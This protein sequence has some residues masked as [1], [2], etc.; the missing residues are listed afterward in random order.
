MR[1]PPLQEPRRIDLNA[2]LGEGV[3]DD[4]A[5]LQVVTSANV[6]CGFHAGDAAVMR[7]VC[8]GAAEL[9]VV[10][11]AQV[12]YADRE[13]FGRRRMDVAADVLTDWVAEQ[14]AALDEI[15]A[16]AGTRVRYVK[17]HGA[18]YN[19]I[20][21]DAEQAAAVLR[22]S[23]DLPVLGLPG[24]VVL[25]LAS[26]QGREVVAEGFP[27][28]GY[29]A[30]GRLIPRDRP[31]ALVEG[32]DRVAAHAVALAGSGRLR[33]VCVHGDSPGAVATAEAVRAALLADGY[34]VRAW[35]S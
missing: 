5:L 2:D 30:E 9:G 4:P 18:L 17:A 12:S 19:R 7:A 29:T 11:G 15:A 6:A 8:A 34:D 3:T 14:V 24:S 1:P 31:G 10:V 28:R 20:A 22:G 25:E 32:S 16:A 21:D 26:E 13:G 33:T 23:G 35:L 27:D